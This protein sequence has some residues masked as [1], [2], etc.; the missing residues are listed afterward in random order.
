MA[1]KRAH[2]SLNI[3]AL[4]RSP[5]HFPAIS[6]AGATPIQGD[7]SEHDKLADLAEQ[8]DIVINAAEADDI[9]VTEALLRGFKKRKDDGKG[10]GALVHVSGT[11][12]FIQGSSGRWEDGLKAWDVSF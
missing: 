9:K 4:V 1:L 2:P 6:A 8:A 10:V 3:T 11:A 5:S 12:V 7:F